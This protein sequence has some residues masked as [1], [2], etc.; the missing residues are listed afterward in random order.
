MIATCSCDEGSGK[1]PVN[2]FRVN[3]IPRTFLSL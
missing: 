1:A 2:E 3:E